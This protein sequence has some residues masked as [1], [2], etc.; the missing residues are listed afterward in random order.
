MRAPRRLHS[1]P[2]TLRADFGRNGSEPPKTGAVYRLE[3]EAT[4]SAVEIVRRFRRELT[5]V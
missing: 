2:P 5:E 4:E 3:I 1:A